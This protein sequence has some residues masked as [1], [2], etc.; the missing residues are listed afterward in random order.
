MFFRVQV[1]LLFLFCCSFLN[2]RGFR[3]DSNFYAKGDY[4][5]V[6]FSTIP[7]F[8]ENEQTFEERFDFNVFGRPVS[9]SLKPNEN[10]VSPNFKTYLLDQGESKMIHTFPQNCHYLHRDSE[11][12]AAI[13]ICQPKSVQGLLILEN[14]TFEIHPLPFYFKEPVTSG[15]D[16][17][18]HLIRKAV[19]DP[20]FSNLPNVIR[21]H[22]DL[23]SALA[24]QQDRISSTT[25]LTAELGL[26]FDAEAYRIFAPYFNHDD[27]KIIEMILIYINSVQ[28]LYH[29]S[30]I[31]TFL[32]L[33]LVRLELM[34]T[35]PE[36][37]PHYDGEQS[38]LLDSFCSYQKSI[39]SEDDDDPNHWDMGLYISGLDFYANENSGKSEGTM[40]L[41]TVGGVCYSQYSCV[42]AELG[43]ASLFGKPYPSAGF[44]SVFVLA[45]EIG[46]NLGMH[47]DGSKNNCPKEGFIMSATRG[48]SGEA[49]W[50]SCSAEVMNKLNNAKCLQDSIATPNAK[51]DHSRFK[52]VPGQIYVAKKQCE[53]LLKD[54][55]AIVSTNQKISDICYSLECKTPH[56]SGT[57]FSGP[58][59]EGTECGK[60]MYCSGGECVSGLVSKSN[61]WKQTVVRSVQKSYP[62]LQRK[63]KDSIDDEN[64]IFFDFK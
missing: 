56:R 48:D 37:M 58:A 6:Y 60:N 41:A 18:P 32:N 15:A 17:Y 3:I 13:S 61:V 4:E 21:R 31:G 51:F 16:K 7:S 55:D 20:A 49:Q 10:L 42:I 2:S 22:I 5:I 53:I 1:S 29:H 43:T 64:N 46:H 9:L 39:N 47:H 26:F 35:Q 23:E 59:L 14:T 24:F 28:A 44:T 36:Q 19:F 30:S 8:E 34:K 12:V 11:T 45:H 27:D 62:H 54:A 50:S 38:Q 40:G 57:Y 25:P 33:V 63:I 52:D